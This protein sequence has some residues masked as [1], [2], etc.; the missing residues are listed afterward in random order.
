ML[1]IAGELLRRGHQLRVLGPPQQRELVVSAGLEFI[2]YRHALPWSPRVAITGARFLLRFIFGPFTDP[3]LGRDVRNEIVREP[4]D[5]AVVDS[6]ILAAVRA[7]EQAK[8]PTAV[9]RH[10]LHRYH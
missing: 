10:T 7:A 4:V 2:A 3:R 5:L 6:M 8:V 1:G 9:L